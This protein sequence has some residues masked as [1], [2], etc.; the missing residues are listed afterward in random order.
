MKK[1]LMV[2]CVSIFLLMAVS[3]SFA[4]SHEMK[5]KKEIQ[6]SDISRNPEE[7]LLMHRQFF[8]PKPKAENARKPLRHNTLHPPTARKP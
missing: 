3:I 5:M 2:S 6:P 8:P 1:I 7:Q 4:D